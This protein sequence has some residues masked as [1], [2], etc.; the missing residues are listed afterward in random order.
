MRGLPEGPHFHIRWGVKEQ[1]DWECFETH[2][3][4]EGLARELARPGE[5]FTVEE[6]PEACPRFRM[7]SAMTN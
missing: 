6:V 4:A 3:E 7:K 1:L 2:A 5:T